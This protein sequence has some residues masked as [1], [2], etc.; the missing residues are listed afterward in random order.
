MIFG[1]CIRGFLFAKAAGSYSLLGG[2]G[3]NS[4]FF[5]V[6]LASRRSP[7][8]FLL[9]AKCIMPLRKRI[10]KSST[11]VGSSASFSVLLCKRFISFP[12]KIN[13]IYLLYTKTIQFIYE[14]T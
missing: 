8:D 7:V 11:Y 1:F 2:G 3:G 12:F 14:K 10:L 13:K 6:P 5:I 4:S 9:N